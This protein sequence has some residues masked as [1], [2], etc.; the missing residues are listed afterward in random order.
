MLQLTSQKKPS[1]TLGE[2][3]RPGGWGGRVDPNEMEP[4]S[5]AKWG[6]GES[7]RD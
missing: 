2:E 6:R 3:F 1:E 7:V 4:T 5:W